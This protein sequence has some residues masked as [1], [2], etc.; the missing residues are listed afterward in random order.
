MLSLTG[1]ALPSLANP[2]LHS[3]PRPVA[4]PGSPALPGPPALRDLADA[5]RSLLGTLSGQ[6]P[7]Y[8]CERSRYTLLAP[9]QDGKRTLYHAPCKS[10]RCPHCGRRNMYRK[11][12]RIN[13]RL[14][15]DRETGLAESTASEFVTTTVRPGALSRAQAYAWIKPAMSYAIRQVRKPRKWTKNMKRAAWGGCELEYINDVDIQPGT[16]MPHVHALYRVR[17][18][19]IVK[20]HGVEQM[21]ARYGR[22]LAKELH[23][24]ANNWLRKR[25]NAHAEALHTAAILAALVKGDAALFVY[26]SA[27]CPAPLPS[28]R[29][30]EGDP[31][32]YVGRESIAYVHFSAARSTENCVMYMALH[33]GKIWT[34]GRDYPRNYRRFA[35]SRGFLAKEEKE[36]SGYEFVRHPLV[37]AAQKLAGQGVTL[38]FSES[39]YG[40]DGVLLSFAFRAAP[41]YHCWETASGVYR[42][43]ETKNDY[44]LDYAL[45]R[46]KAEPVPR[47]ITPRF[48]PPDLA[49][50]M[51]ALE[52]YW[53]SNADTDGGRYEDAVNRRGGVHGRFVPG[54]SFEEWRSGLASLSLSETAP[55]ARRGQDDDP[56]ADDPPAPSLPVALL[57]QAWDLARSSGLTFSASL[58][59]IRR[60]NAV[61]RSWS[62]GVVL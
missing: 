12:N 22:R 57:D 21:R 59:M 2:K 16:G 25:L 6:K 7:R 62:G 50:K 9:E 20:R 32:P 8:Y 10:N 60:V 39:E 47:L 58:A 38:D 40:Y 5:P 56:F 33:N 37:L 36:P 27:H 15:L 46:A 23:Y 24:Y 4:L 42:Q 30:R 45:G 43:T 13:D 29:W 3:V 54:L 52:D 41:A 55:T 17:F 11:R 53:A 49:E 44:R 14:K 35:T 61:V 1:P 48:L 34:D 18:P 19:G 51:Q 28:L 26:L 31:Y